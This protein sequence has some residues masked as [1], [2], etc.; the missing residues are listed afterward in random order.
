MQQTDKFYPRVNVNLS[1]GLTVPQHYINQGLQRYYQKIV[2]ENMQWDEKMS[3][4]GIGSNGATMT[5]VSS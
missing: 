2:L 1:D 4:P 3:L 5:F